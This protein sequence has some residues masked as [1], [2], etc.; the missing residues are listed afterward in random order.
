[1]S[2]KYLTKSSFCPSFLVWVNYTKT[3]L[4]HIFNQVR[5]SSN[6][7]NFFKKEKIAKE[8]QDGNKSN[9]RA[10]SQD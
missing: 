7:I 10:E 4:T 5:D 6:Y 9:S 2:D 8:F 1:V 3:Q